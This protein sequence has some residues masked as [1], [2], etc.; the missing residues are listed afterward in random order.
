MVIIITF[1]RVF[2]LCF[3]WKFTIAC[4]ELCL[5]DIWGF[6]SATSS[7]LYD[8]YSKKSK[9][10][11]LDF[12][13]TI[14]ETAPTFHPGEESLVTLTFIRSTCDLWVSYAIFVDSLSHCWHKKV[15]SLR[16]QF[17]SRRTL[18]WHLGTIFWRL[19]GQFW[20]PPTPQ[21]NHTIETRVID[22]CA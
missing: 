12:F 11:S 3:H 19:P 22:V 17:L 15:H 8:Y 1:F 20:R 7:F 18:S 5:T 2:L 16:Y 10:C 13:T 21:H 4:C 9:A 14:I 6:P